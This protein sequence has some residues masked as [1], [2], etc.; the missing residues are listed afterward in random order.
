VPVT[1]KFLNRP[2]W[3]VLPVGTLAPGAFVESLPL[4]LD[5]DAPF[6]MVG[7]GGRCA[8]AIT[9]AGGA[10]Y[11]G[12]QAAM[13]GLSFRFQNRDGVWLAPQ[14][15]LP[16]LGDVPGGGFGGAWKPVYPRQWFPANGI[17]NVDVYNNGSVPIPNLQLYFYGFKQYPPSIGYNSYPASCSPSDFVYSYWSQPPQSN[18]APG[19]TYLQVA[20]P[21]LR[22][23]QLTINGDAD[24]VLRSGQASIQTFFPGLSPIVPYYSEIFLVLKDPDQKPYMNAP[25]HID[26]L[27]G[28]SS[29]VP[30]LGGLSWVGYPLQQSY[31]V[32][33]FHPGLFCPE[34]YMR[35]N[36]TWLFDLYRDDS[37]YTVANGAA[38]DAAPVNLN[39]AW[40]GQKVFHR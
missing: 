24:F 30:G 27:F 23:L 18:L 34:I 28:N 16:W 17:V 11:A 21:A 39:I 1:P 31:L 20:A 6:C 5:A 40:R 32:G 7:R 15:G 33:N 10:N 9:N 13:A 14:G 8:N 19:T 29:R 3:Y 25:V 12:G 22:N 4:A 37:A 36:S 2:Q 35:A 38:A 26:W